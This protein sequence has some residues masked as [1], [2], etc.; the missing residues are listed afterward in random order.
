MPDRTLLLDT[1]VLLNLAAGGQ[2]ESVLETNHFLPGRIATAVREESLYLISESDP[3][4]FEP[5]DVQP[6]IDRR[7][8]SVVE[9]ETDDEYRLFVNT[10]ATPI[11]DGEAMSIAIAAARGWILATDDRKARRV[12][13]RIAPDADRLTGTTTLL[14][15]WSKS[16]SS[17]DLHHTLG[18]IQRRAHFTPGKSDPNRDWW[19][20]IVSATE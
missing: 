7:I 6:L 13:T 5:I 4:E 10:A 12:Y 20:K 17:E 15:E 9:L 14:R 18:T 8:L 2:L 11:G 3:G 19:E 16:I 1:C